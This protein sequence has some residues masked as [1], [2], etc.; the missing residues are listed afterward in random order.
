MS[1][2]LRSCPF[3]GSDDITAEPYGAEYFCC[4]NCEA[5]GPISDTR[6]NLW[7]TRAPDPAV[8]ALEAEVTRL[9]GLV[10]EAHC[11]GWFNAYDAFLGNSED[12]STQP[13]DWWTSSA[14]ATL[15]PAPSEKE[16]G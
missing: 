6:G 7:N 14:R 10:K 4:R 3:C 2:D 13:D 15:N 16:A 9:R 1:G 8:A 5:V 11:E 12:N